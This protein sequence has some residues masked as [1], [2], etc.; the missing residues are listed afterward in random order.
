MFRVINVGYVRLVADLLASFALDLESFYAAKKGSSDRFEPVKR[1]S[2][3]FRAKIRAA[4][5]FPVSPTNRIPDW[6]IWKISEIEKVH[7]YRV[8]PNGI[9][10]IPVEVV[11]THSATMQWRFP[12]RSSL[13]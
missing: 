10:G 1:F 12:V 2:D 13:A 7:W 11:A 8:L 5:L 3:R 9:C 6:S 4:R